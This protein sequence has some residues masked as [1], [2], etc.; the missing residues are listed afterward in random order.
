V[1][2]VIFDFLQAGMALF[3]DR[4]STRRRRVRLGYGTAEKAR[5]T[6]K[7]LRGQP[8]GYARRAAQTMYFRAK[9]HAQQTPDMREAM[10]VYKAYLKTF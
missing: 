3:N 9:Y 8:R 2:A 6:V 10:K 1:V 4:R 7:A 5:A